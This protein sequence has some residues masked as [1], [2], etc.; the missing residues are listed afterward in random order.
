MSKPLLPSEKEVLLWQ[1]KSEKAVMTMLEKHYREALTGI[2]LKIAQLLGRGDANLPHVIRRIEYQRMIKEQV[3]AAL[4][5]LH[6]KEYET[7]SEYLNETYTDAFVGSVYT[8]H[9]QDMPLILPVDQS[10]AVKAVTIDSKL[11]TDLYTALGVDVTQLKKRI[12]SEITRGIASSMLY[13]EIARNIKNAS[14][15]SLRRAKTITRTEAG[16]VQ[17]QAHYDS[18]QKAKS[19][20]ADVVKQWSAI[21]D[22]K[23]RDSHRMLDGQIRE[24]DEPFEVNGHK[25]MHPHDFGVA[26]EDI[27]CRCTMLT[28]ARKALDADELK[29]LQ[30]TAAYHGLQVKDSKKL[31]QAQAKNIAE[32]KKKYLQAAEKTAE[33]P[34]I[35]FV[36][37]KTK[38]EAE[39]FAEQFAHTIDYKGVSLENANIINEQ[40]AV[41]TSKYPI[42]KLEELATGGRGS[43]SANYKKLLISRNKLGKALSD[44][45]AEFLRV[46]QET[47][48]ALQ[49]IKER[50]AGKKLPFDV[51][52]NVEKLE[53][54]LRFNRW[55][56]HGVYED[57]V[58][59]VV[60]HEYGHIVSDQYFGLINGDSANPN[61]KLNWS[62][63]AVS[64]KWK[65]IY[66]KAYKD[67]DIY[68]V[69]QYG[70]TDH[71]EF[72]AECF[73]AREIGEKLPD[74]IEEFM[75]EVLKNGIL[76]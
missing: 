8:M 76:Q 57:H 22:A 48:E 24:V 30:E 29:Y 71:K 60:T 28:R 64:D 49:T 42:N 5:A 4:D 68:H 56:V 65:K 62:I 15:I 44:G 46:Q 51:R 1:D 75:S 47:R 16:R 72:F 41:L 26:E 2:N 69:S 21:R 53:N 7:I 10:A 12:A 43:M 59:W 33:A 19:V 66:E 31:G 34:A 9:N 73:V 18:A 11:K 38:D 55:G 50:Y 17:E 58:K 52:K 35:K 32:F 54:S 40:L 74:Y 39:T 61:I 13:D 25:G 70:A 3:K 20:G 27:N 6:A 23:T 67:G 37:A 45:H 63:K 14:G 36:P